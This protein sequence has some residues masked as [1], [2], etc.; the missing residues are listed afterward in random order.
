MDAESRTDLEIKVAFQDKLIADLDALVRIFGAR[1]DEL[2]REV[3]QLKDAIH[4]PE[5]PLGPVN[6]RPPHY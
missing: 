3:K 4:S 2:A 5:D 6:E 1:L